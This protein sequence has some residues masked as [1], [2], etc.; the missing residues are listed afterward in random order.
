MVERSVEFFERQYIKM[1]EGNLLQVVEMA[2]L[3]DNVVSTCGYGAVDELVIVLVD[4]AEQVEME[5]RLAVV[6]AAGG[7]GLNEDV[8]VDNYKSH[9]LAD[10]VF[11]GCA[12]VLAA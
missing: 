12:Q 4:V 8:S 3:G 2:V 11:I 10:L 6:Q 9:R 7:Q 1:R 5:E